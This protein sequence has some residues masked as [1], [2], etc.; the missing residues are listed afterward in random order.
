MIHDASPRTSVLHTERM[1]PDTPKWTA[2]YAEHIVRYQKAAAT[3]VTGRA[4]D[5]GCGVGYGSAFLADRGMAEVIG[6]D[7]S[8]EAVAKA[9]KH[10]PRPNVRFLQD[11]AQLLAKVEGPFDLITAFEVYEHVPNPDAILTRAA[12]L[13]APGG[14]FLC[15][16]PNTLFRPKLE[17]GVTPRNPFHIREYTFTEFREALGKHFGEVAVLGQ[18]PS[19]SYTRLAAVLRR[20]DEET[21]RRDQS[22][23]SNPF[24]RLGRWIQRLKGSTSVWTESVDPLYPP[25]PDDIVFTESDVEASRDFLAICRLPHKRTA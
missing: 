14:Y 22:L 1:L 25:E 21:K 24:V 9:G 8:E 20:L 23:W 10:F 17:D 3:G 18:D 11:D 5:I 4:L 6:I 12:A 13:L 2:G 19:P 15:S 16:T 7:Y